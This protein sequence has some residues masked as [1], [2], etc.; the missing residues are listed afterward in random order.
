MNYKVTPKN[1][2]KAIACFMKHENLFIFGIDMMD[3]TGICIEDEYEDDTEKWFTAIQKELVK[4]NFYTFWG[5]EAFSPLN[6]EE[7]SIDFEE[8]NWMLVVDFTKIHITKERP[9]TYMGKRSF[10]F[11]YLD[12][13]FEHDDIKQEWYSAFD[14]YAIVDEFEPHLSW[15]CHYTRFL[16]T[17]YFNPYGIRQL[18][19]YEPETVPNN[20]VA[21]NR[22][23]KKDAREAMDKLK[24]ILINRPKK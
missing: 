24:D 5:E 3:L 18:P 22:M 6:E 1:V 9:T 2:A 15:H 14:M 11:K 16:A 23:T 13:H 8:C 19:Q 12:Q 17:V 10:F 4:S 20:V 21:I 7:F